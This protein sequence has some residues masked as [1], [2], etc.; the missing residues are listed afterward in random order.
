M[1]LHCFSGPFGEA[2]SVRNF[3]TNSTSIL[4]G[5]FFVCKFVFYTVWQGK[6]CI[7][8]PAVHLYDTFVRVT[9]VCP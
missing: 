2:T 8:D 6:N 9:L 1:G 3:R 4:V 5:S 7:P